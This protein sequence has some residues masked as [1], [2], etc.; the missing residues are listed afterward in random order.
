I[1]RRLDGLPLAIELAAARVRL[2][3]PP[4]LLARLEHRLALLTGGP[5]DAPARPQTLPPTPDWSPPQL[6]P[7]EPVLFARLAVF[8]GGWTLEAAEAVCA[9]ADGQ[10]L[11]VLTALESLVS[12][13]L[14]RRATGADGEPR[15]DMLETIREYATERLDASGEAATCLQQHAR[16][17]L[18]LAEAAAGVGRGPDLKPW[19]DRLDREHDNLRAALGWALAQNEA[20][21][22]LRFVAALREFWSTRGHHSEGQRWTAA[23][24]AAGG[25][26]SPALR[27]PALLTAGRLATVQRDFAAATTAA[28]ASGAL[29]TALGDRRG[30][31]E[32]A[33]LQ[34]FNAA[35]QGD[36]VATRAYNEAALALWQSLGDQRGQA[37]AHRELGWAAL[38]AGDSL[39]ARDHLTA[40]LTLQQA[41][42][43]PAEIADT[44]NHLGVAAALAGDYPAARVHLSQALA[45]WQA[46][47]DRPRLASVLNNL[48]LVEAWAGDFTAAR[49]LLSEVLAIRRALGGQL[50]IARAEA[51]LAM[52]AR[53]EGA[54][55]EAW[56]LLAG[57]L[58]QML[59]LG[60][61]GLPDAAE[62]LAGL[63][64]AR[65]L[66][67]HAARL[68]GAT[69]AW[70]TTK[71]AAPRLPQNETQYQRDLAAA[72]AQCDAATWDAAWA[73][74]SA[75]ALEDAITEA[76]AIGAPA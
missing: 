72:R 34:G 36:P 1:C 8:A 23:A 21:L 15:L 38:M 58:P 19:L 7:T 70:R 59:V 33:L 41:I 71:A 2:L 73:A 68:Y 5:R 54:G 62:D 52:V 26:A 45:F 22:A 37:I 56:T 31:A 42:G 10:A 24:L 63:L 76:L 49:A 11:D 28:A 35:N 75:L 12:K 40:A 4:A 43:W 61:D 69:A 18:T 3:P 32:V 46:L 25:A 53:L 48:G 47:D 57:A 9:A 65:G 39:A 74:G 14:V 55:A 6:D 29:Y 20:E 44:R 51:N 13:S 66:V 60:D 50:G 16:Y 30:E 27:A 17:F 67:C 64:V